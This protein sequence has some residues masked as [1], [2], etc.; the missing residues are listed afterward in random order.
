MVTARATEAHRVSRQP[1]HS[2]TSE[3]RNRKTG[4]PDKPTQAEVHIGS[5]QMS[6]GHASIGNRGRLLSKAG[7]MLNILNAQLSPNPIVAP[8]LPMAATGRDRPFAAMRTNGRIGPQADSRLT[9]V[10][11][12]LRTIKSTDFI[13]LLTDYFHQFAKP[14]DTNIALKSFTFVRVGPVRTRLSSLSK[15][16]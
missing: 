10:G 6:R 12:A 15:K 3:H 9:A 8:W 1:H 2:R 14:H 11:S 16:L 13:V 7:S 5:A 4:M